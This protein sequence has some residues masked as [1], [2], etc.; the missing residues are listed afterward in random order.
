MSQHTYARALTIAT[1]VGATEEQ[2]RELYARL[3][4][5][6]IHLVSIDPSPEPYTGER[7]RPPADLLNEARAAIAK[8]QEEAKR[9]ELERTPTTT[10]PAAEEQP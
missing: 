2:A 3:H 1:E 4:A 10:D 9:A 5:A 8:A 6:G 7:T